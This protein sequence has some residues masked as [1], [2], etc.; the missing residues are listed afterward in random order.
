MR[1]LIPFPDNRKAAITLSSSPPLEPNVGNVI[2]DV[3]VFSHR[4]IPVHGDDIWNEFEEL[5]HIKN[6]CFFGS[7]VQQ[8]WEKFR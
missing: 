3:D 1:V 8:Y 6:Q 2:L 5:R 7:L 4:Q